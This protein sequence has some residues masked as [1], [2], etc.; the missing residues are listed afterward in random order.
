MYCDIEKSDEWAALY[1]GHSFS[2]CGMVGAAWVLYKAFSQEL[3]PESDAARD[4]R[5]MP[6][7]IL[8]VSAPE[9]RAVRRIAGGTAEGDPFVPITG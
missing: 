8:G 2:E 9:K 6:L 3:L 4:R 7:P 5:V 1:D